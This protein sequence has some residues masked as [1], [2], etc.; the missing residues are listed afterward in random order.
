[1]PSIPVPNKERLAGCGTFKA[2]LA[3]CGILRTAG[4]IKKSAASNETTPLL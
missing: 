2:R 4:S 1:M 3:G